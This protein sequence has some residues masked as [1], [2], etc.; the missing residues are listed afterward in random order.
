M[1]SSRFTLIRLGAQLSLIWH[2]RTPAAPAETH[3]HADG[4]AYSRR[5]VVRVCLTCFYG[6]GVNQYK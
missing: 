5:I 4:S 1:G 3:G 2:D 6:V